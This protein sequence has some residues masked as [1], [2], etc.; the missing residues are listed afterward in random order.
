M[1]LAVTVKSGPSSPVFHVGL[2]YRP[3]LTTGGFESGSLIAICD[4]RE[5]LS[6]APGT[7][8]ADELIFFCNCH[9]FLL[10]DVQCRVR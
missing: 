9:D 4:R 7:V 2:E 1:V 6:A 10:Y 8:D 5:I 3:D